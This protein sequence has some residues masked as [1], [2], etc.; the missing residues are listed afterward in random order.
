MARK[1][2][3]QA[4]RLK[5]LEWNK[6]VEQK[7]NLDFERS[8]RSRYSLPKEVTLLR[9]EEKLLREIENSCYVMVF[10]NYNHN[11]CGLL[12]LSQAN[13]AKALV[14]RLDALS[15]C[16]PA[17]K[18]SIINGTIHRN[19][20]EGNYAKL[21]DTVPK[22]IDTIYESSFAGEGRVFFFTLETQEKRNFINVVTVKRRHIPLD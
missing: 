16:T 20:A 14:K 4:K 13:E 6:E 7:K 18:Q 11:Q 9:F 19:K 15:R 3:K 17:R 1:R 12:E 22:D 8:E 10:G 2:D 5:A 21:F